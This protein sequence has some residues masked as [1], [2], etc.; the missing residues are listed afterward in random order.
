MRQS[1]KSVLH[2]GPAPLGAPHGMVRGG[3]HGAAVTPTRVQP[4]SPCA[5]PGTQSMT[6]R[7]RS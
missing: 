4:L 1:G 3:T 6:G 5:G 7:A 2:L